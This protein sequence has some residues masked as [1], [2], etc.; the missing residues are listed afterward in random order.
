MDKVAHKEQIGIFFKPKSW[1][2]LLNNGEKLDT[3][4]FS[5]SFVGSE[6]CFLLAPQLCLCSRFKDVLELQGQ[7]VMWVWYVSQKLDTYLY[8]MAKTG[9]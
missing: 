5:A 8:L 1:M 9:S 6:R 2:S 3:F 4:H 7:M